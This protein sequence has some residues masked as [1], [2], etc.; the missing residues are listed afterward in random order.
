MANFLEYIEEDIQ[1]KK[2]LFSS[3]PVNTKTNKRKFNAK[4]DEVF[5]TYT[6]YKK[7]IKK[8]LELKS[9]SFNVI[10]NRNTADLADKISKLENIRFI[11]NPSNTYFEK[12]GFDTLFY[13][14]SN[15][16]DVNF[17]S[18]NNIFNEFINKFEMVNIKLNKNDFNYTYYVNQFMISFMDIR[19]SDNKNIDE[20]TEI[21]EKIYWENPEIISHIELNFRK[22]IRKNEKY[23]IDY[24]NKLKKEL[25]QKNNIDYKSCIDKLTNLYQEMKTIGEEN[26]SDIIELAKKGELDVNH[27]FEESK[28]RVSTYSSLMLDSLNVENELVMNKFYE[29]LAKLKENVEEYANYVKFSPLINDFKLKYIKKIDSEI[30]KNDSN[31]QLKELESQINKNENKLNKLNKKIFGT[32]NKFF[33]HK[34]K[35][36]T[37]LKIESVRQAAELYG[38]Y[39]NYN[40]EYFKVKVLDVISNNFAL[41]DLLHIYYSFDYYKKEAIKNSYEI[42][43]YDE[44]IEYSDS[45]DLFALDLTNVIV[46]PVN[47]FDEVSVA[48][49]IINKYRLL[50]INITNED[51]YP[52]NIDSFT[53][54]INLILRIQELEKSQ[55]TIEKLWFMVQVNKFLISESEK[56]IK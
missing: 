14:I 42:N 46:C 37:D 1:S 30:N 54:R 53:E 11:L 49:V 44:L 20:L 51:L 23:F 24:I 17:S 41:K 38:L 39:Q 15:S 16:Q 18:L 3:M 56:Q 32:T 7:S 45:F 36:A 48:K 10:D 55:L 35:N 4:I 22:L 21:F 19:K 2:I 28:V 5:N 33:I 13:Q 25:I 26:V 31:K 50:N 6:E 29:S 43:S 27:F 47:A 8:Y 52:E 34:E 40:D 12:M 9:K